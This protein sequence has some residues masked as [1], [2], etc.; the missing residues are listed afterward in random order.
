VT[1][2]V[3][4]KKTAETRRNEKLQE[5]MTRRNAI[6]EEIRTMKKPEEEAQREE[7]TKQREDETKSEKMRPNIGKLLESGL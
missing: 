5:T 7:E 2:L 1:R 3:L 6:E 4:S